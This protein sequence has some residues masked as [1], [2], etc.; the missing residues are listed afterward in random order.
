MEQYRNAVLD[1]LKMFPEYT[2]SIV[3]RSQNHMVDS[4][5]TAASNFKI[6][7][8]SNKNFEIHLKHQPSIPNNLRYWQVLWDEKQVNNFLQS[9]GEFEN[10]SMDEVYNEDDQVIK[11]TQVDILQLKDDNIPKGLVPLEDLFDQDDVARK[12]TLVPTE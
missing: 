11:V 2:L 7:I 9:E 6:P 12:P 4:L 10:C 3:P 5:A 8:F 1:I